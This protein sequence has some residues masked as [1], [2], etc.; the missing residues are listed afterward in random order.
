[1]STQE[2]DESLRRRVFL[3]LK[4]G[5]LFP[6]TSKSWVGPGTGRVCIVCDQRIDPGNVEHEVDGPHGPVAAH[7]ACY[8]IW[9]QESE[10]RRRIK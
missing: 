9:L 10:A 2:G 1:M 3:G 5:A 8:T 7:Q 4:S 6:V